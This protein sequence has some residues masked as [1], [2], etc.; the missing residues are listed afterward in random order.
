MSDTTV[1][2]PRF[3]IAKVSCVRT[4]CFLAGA[5]MS[6]HALDLAAIK[7][8]AD[9]ATP[10]EIAYADWVKEVE[11]DEMPRWVHIADTGAGMTRMVHAAFVAGANHAK[12]RFDT[13]T[14]ALL[15]AIAERDAE[16]ERLRSQNELMRRA[17]DQELKR[18]G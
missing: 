1:P 4:L 5:Q 7:A 11:A 9:A 13:D 17:N 16:I 3:E 6:G 12:E 8:R 14:A 18:N 2:T 10:P 15:N